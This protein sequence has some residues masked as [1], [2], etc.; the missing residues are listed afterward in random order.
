MKS[1][2]EVSQHYFEY[3]PLRDGV[4]MLTTLIDYGVALFQACSPSTYKLRRGA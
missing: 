1:S 4:I 3:F 2:A